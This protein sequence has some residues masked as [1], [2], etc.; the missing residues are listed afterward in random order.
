MKM[1]TNKER[2]NLIRQVHQATTQEEVEAAWTALCAWK[3][4]YPND[5]GIEDGFEMLAL[6]RTEAATPLAKAS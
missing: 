2:Q 3:R 5:L 4:A 6:L 1:T